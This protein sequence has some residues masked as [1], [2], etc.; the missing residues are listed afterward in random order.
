LRDVEGLLVEVSVSRSITL[1]AGL[2][3]AAGLALAAKPAFADATP[4]PGANCFLSTQWQGWRA[5]NPSVI[6]VRVNVSDVWRFDLSAPAQ[7]LMYPSVHLFSE[8]RGSPWICTPLDLQMYVVDDSPTRVREPLFVK[9]ITR[10]TTD[11]I[12]AIPPKYRP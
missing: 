1:A 5:P 10:L 9:S 4:K 3:A 11:E 12:Q 7:Q 2:L 8:I 6:F